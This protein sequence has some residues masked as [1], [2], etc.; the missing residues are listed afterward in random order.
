MTIKAEAI[1]F[2]EKPLESETFFHKIK[3]ILKQNHDINKLMN[4]SL[5][6]TEIKVL[7]LVIKGHSNKDI[8]YLLNRSKRTVEAHR[9]NIMGKF[10]VDNFA[11]L[12]KKSS[13]IGLVEL[14]ESYGLA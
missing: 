5:T 8:A 12:I 7:K 6:K 1:D 4:R 10:C 3:S 11:E 14:P 9:A 13:S 2:L